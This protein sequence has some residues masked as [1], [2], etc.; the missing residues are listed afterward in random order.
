MKCNLHP[1]AS[2]L[3]GRNLYKIFPLSINVCNAQSGA[4]PPISATRLAVKHNQQQCFSLLGS[5]MQEEKA[6]LTYPQQTLHCSH[7]CRLILAYWLTCLI[8]FAF[9]SSFKLPIGLHGT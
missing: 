6:P 9:T 4:E 7:F 8:F 2:L 1:S 5:V 3:A